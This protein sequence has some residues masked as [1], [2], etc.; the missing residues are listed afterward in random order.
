MII[1]IVLW[2]KIAAV[3]SIANHNVSCN[4]TII[5]RYFPILTQ[6]WGPE[7]LSSRTALIVIL[8]C[9]ILCIDLMRYFNHLRLCDPQ[10][11]MLSIRKTHKHVKL[12][13]EYAF[14]GKF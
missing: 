14:P 6:G 3:L 8:L 9:I 5:L 11:H 4:Q 7:I 12:A 1:I 2:F 10:L 13:W